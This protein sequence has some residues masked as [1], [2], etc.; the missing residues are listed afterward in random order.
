MTPEQARQAY[1]KMAAMFG[2]PRTGNEMTA[3][4]WVDRLAGLETDLCRIAV[5]AV[6]A[7]LDWFPSWHQFRDAYDGAR[8]ARWN[9]RTIQTS[10]TICGMCGQQGGHMA[11]C[12]NSTSI[13]AAGQRGDMSLRYE[14]SAVAVHPKDGQR[15]LDMLSHGRDDPKARPVP[16]SAERRAE[17]K[18]I[19]ESARDRAELRLG[20]RPGNI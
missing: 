12:D 17:Q 7:E 5:D 6:L 16:L 18:E 9:Q 8:V 11:W 4:V 20:Y 10:G 14:W 13:R 1:E 2:S 15:G 19:A 3:E